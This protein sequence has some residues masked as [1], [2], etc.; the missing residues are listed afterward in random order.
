MEAPHHWDR[1]AQL[2]HVPDELELMAV[3]QLGYLPER[4]H[5]LAVDWSSRERKRPSQFVFRERCATPQQGWDD[6]IRPGAA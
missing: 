6:A 3:Y 5:R 2:L 1:I 4:T